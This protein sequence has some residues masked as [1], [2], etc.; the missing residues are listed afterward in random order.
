MAPRTTRT[1]K[2]RSANGD[3]KVS[4]TRQAETIYPETVYTFAENLLK[5][6]NFLSKIKTVPSSRPGSDDEHDEDDDMQIGED[7][8]EAAKELRK[9][10]CE[11]YEAAEGDTS[12]GRWTLIS[13]MLKPP[14][15][16]GKYSVWVPPRPTNRVTLEKAAKEKGKGDDNKSEETVVGSSL[17][18]RKAAELKKKVHSWQLKVVEEAQ[19]QPEEQV[20]L[21]ED[22]HD[23]VV[24][25]VKGKK[26]TVKRT[27]SGHDPLD[28]SPLGFAVQK[29]SSMRMKSKPKPSASV[30]G[31]V[32]SS[33]DEPMDHSD[34]EGVTRR[35][36]I[37]EIPETSF[38]P[39]SFSSSQI[40]HSTPINQLAAP[41][42]QPSPIPRIQDESHAAP[43]ISSSPLSPS[44]M[45]TSPLVAAETRSRA[46]KSPETSKTPFPVAAT[47]T[48]RFTVN[49]PIAGLGLSSS[50]PAI[51]SP[52]TPTRAAIA[53]ANLARASHKVDEDSAATSHQKRVQPSPVGSTRPKKLLRPDDKS[54]G[55]GSPSTARGVQVAPPSSPL[56]STPMTPKKGPGAAVPTLT[57]LL[58]A[59]KPTPKGKRLSSGGVLEVRLGSASPARNE[60]NLEP[61]EMVATS[62]TQSA[63]EKTMTIFPSTSQSQIEHRGSK[64]ET[65]RTTTTATSLPQRQPGWDELSIQPSENEFTNTNYAN[66]LDSTSAHSHPA[67]KPLSSIGADS[68]SSED[69]YVTPAAPEGDAGEVQTPDLMNR[70]QG[71]SQHSAKEPVIVP[72]SPL[73][74]FTLDTDAFAPQLASTQQ[75]AI[76]DKDFSVSLASPKHK[77]S[78]LRGGAARH[79]SQ[80]QSQ[81]LSRS[82]SKTPQQIQSQ[83]GSQSQFQFGYSSQ[84]DLDGGVDQ[85][86]RFLE[87]DISMD[88]DEETGDDGVAFGGRGWV[89]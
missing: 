10:V 44:R 58:S 27:A 40:E 37:H 71:R 83:P 38:L 35:K 3:V 70:S 41:R 24:E 73:P 60:R 62:Q 79:S 25:P 55:R 72:N 5:R 78:P 14:S 66:A 46:K 64:L 18:E 80:S 21:D 68:D 4:V 32:Q 59:K 45:D 2:K 85:V 74:D 1:S 31:P 52:K 49:P 61:V 75:S 50:L 29:T 54:Y 63:K 23:P 47:P 16:R 7:V 6:Q 65:Q 34:S 67:T 86:S 81:P 13:K 28:P 26:T 88:V 11:A 22:L 42:H 17:S 87:R 57:E 15:T 56:S 30:K 53:A 84:L 43:P 89:Y 76:Q 48:A 33:P 12:S 9:R 77:A 8:R 39:P 82:P 36:A 20:P 19:T 69:V 51:G